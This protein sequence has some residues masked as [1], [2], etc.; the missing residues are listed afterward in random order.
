MGKLIGTTFVIAGRS[1]RNRDELPVVLMPLPTV[2]C[3]CIGPDGDR[4]LAPTVL[5]ISE[6]E[7]YRTVTAAKDG[8][9]EADSGKSPA[10]SPAAVIVMMV[11]PVS[12]PLAG[13]IANTDGI[14]SSMTTYAGERFTPTNSS[15]RR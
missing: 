10:P 12:G 5:V 14:G 8:S 4:P 9:S 7:T 13:V 15:T 6:E 11:P 3:K 2:S 1:N